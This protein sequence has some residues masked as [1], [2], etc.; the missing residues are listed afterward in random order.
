VTE[1]LGER[2]QNINLWKFELEKTIRSYAV[3]SYEKK[4]PPHSLKSLHMYENK[5]MGDLL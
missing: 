4:V 2:L 5:V 1:R 3:Q